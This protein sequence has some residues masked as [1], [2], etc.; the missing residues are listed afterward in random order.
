MPLYIQDEIN[1]LLYEKGTPITINGVSQTAIVE[2]TDKVDIEEI[3]LISKVPLKRGDLI[4][5]DGN[6]YLI[7]S[8]ENLERFDTYYK[9]IVQSCNYSIKFIINNVPISYS[10]I[11]SSKAFD[12]SS[13]T[14]MMLPVGKIMV[15]LQFDNNSNTIQLSDR[16]IKMNSPFKIVGIDKTHQGLIILTCDI[17]LIKTGDDMANEVPT[18]TGNSSH[19]YVLSSTPVSPSIVIGATQQLTTN[20]TDNGVLVNLPSFIYSS[21][22]TTIATVDKNGLIT[23]IALGSAIIVVSFLGL[24]GNTYSKTIAETSV[25]AV[26]RTFTIVGNSNF[27]IGNPDQT[28]TVIDGITGVACTDLTFTYT[29][30]KP[31][32]AN[33]VSSTSNTVT[34]HA[35]AAGQ[36]KLSAI[37][38]TYAPYKIISVAGGF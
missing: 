3:K 29:N 21:V 27:T 13:G 5:V 36:A 17:D 16:I 31:N 2:F 18:Y 26:A 20:V 6:D 12:I 15:T 14:V 38:G 4:F 25:N 33:I 32:C 7:N 11:V 28:Y 9:A 1:F 37:N 35:L 23:G 34:L 30:T 8:E 24:D 10:T 22:N 19:A